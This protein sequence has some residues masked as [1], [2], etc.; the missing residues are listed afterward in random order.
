MEKTNSGILESGI[1]ESPIPPAFLIALHDTAA[2]LSGEKDMV[3]NSWG[4][5]LMNDW[6]SLEL[7]A[8]R[9]R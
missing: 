8:E 5:H 1:L 2:A 6:R 4:L 9:Y 3:L 7:I